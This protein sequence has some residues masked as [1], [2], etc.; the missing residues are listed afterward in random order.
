MIEE[1]ENKKNVK[2]KSLEQPGQTR[3]YQNG[4]EKDETFVS[5][6]ADFVSES[7]IITNLGFTTV[8]MTGHSQR[9]RTGGILAIAF[10]IAKELLSG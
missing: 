8:G 1:R 4:K 10:N 5:I 9:S 7:L 2:A 6:L 3:I